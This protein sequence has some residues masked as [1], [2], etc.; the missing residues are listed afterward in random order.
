M[1][2]DRNHFSSFEAKMY[3]ALGF[4]IFRTF[5][6]VFFFFLVG[7]FFLLC[8]TGFLTS[9][10]G[11]QAGRCS[12]Q[13][14]TDLSCFTELFDGIS[15]RKT[16]SAWQHMLLFIHC[17][18]FKRSCWCEITHAHVHSKSGIWTMLYLIPEK[19]YR[20]KKKHELLFL[21]LLGAIM[22]QPGL[23]K[24]LTL[25]SKGRLH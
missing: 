21:T 10:A 14:L 15:V 3:P 2:I 9:S 7:L 1:G 17:P 8:S 5:Y 20:I 25:L 23:V 22:T 13:T 11:L 6:S 12:S 18:A 4:L 19:S 16:L 24:H